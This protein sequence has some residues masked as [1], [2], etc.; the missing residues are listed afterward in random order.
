MD[1]IV[2]TGG[3]LKWAMDADLVPTN[4]N[5]LMNVIA[6]ARKNGASV[7]YLR[8]VGWKDCGGVLGWMFR[9]WVGDWMHGMVGIGR[10]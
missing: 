4:I 9:V 7:H 8:W 2:H 5:G 10:L 1:A 3:S 6:L